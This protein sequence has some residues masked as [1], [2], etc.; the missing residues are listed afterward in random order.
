MGIGRKCV[1]FLLPHV[2]RTID[3]AVAVRAQYGFDN[4]V[5]HAALMQVVC[6]LDAAS[7]CAMVRHIAFGK[8]AVGEPVLLRE[9]VEQRLDIAR[10]KTRLFQFADK[11]GPAVLAPRQQ[12]QGA[13]TQVA[14]FRLRLQFRR[15]QPGC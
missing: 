2:A 13:F 4:A 12:A 11:F 3:F 5:A 15:R 7:P 10:I 6:Q 8:A 9:L 14:G 1:E